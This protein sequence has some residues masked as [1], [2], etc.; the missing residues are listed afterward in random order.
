MKVEFD[1]DRALQV[2]RHDHGRLQRPGHRR[3]DDEVDT[4]PVGETTS[5]SLGLSDAGGC[6]GQEINPVAT[7]TTRVGVV[8]DAAVAHEK[9]H[10]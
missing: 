1:L 5:E 6:E 3:R 2:P 9:E 10:A 7:E 4:T 8:I